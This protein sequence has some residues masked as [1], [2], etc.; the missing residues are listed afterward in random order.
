RT[1]GSKGLQIYVPLNSPMAYD[2]TKAFSHR[3]A[4]LLEQQSPDIVVSKMQKNMRKGKVFVDWS[5]NDDHKTT[6]CAYS[7][8]AKDR[9]SVS[10]PV[11][12]DEVR[13]ASKKRD[14][15]CLTF[16]SDE[17]LERVE[18]DGDLFAPVLKLKQKLPT[19]D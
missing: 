1:S 17:V 2:K 3:V 18:Q 8:R 6:V 12:W 10:T 9:P 16:T 15:Q 5:Q 14:P 4:E 7:L 19:L 13:T 11:T